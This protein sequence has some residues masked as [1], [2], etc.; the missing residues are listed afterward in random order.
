MK[1]IR[2][3]LTASIALL[4][5]APGL[6]ALADTLSVTGTVAQWNF[7]TLGAVA[8]GGSGT[9]NDNVFYPNNPPFTT[10]GTQ[11]NNNYGEPFATSLGM[12]NSFAY[13]SSGSTIAVGSVPACDI[14]STGGLAASGSYTANA[15]RIRGPASN[16]YDVTSGTPT[17]TGNGW[18]LLAPE[19]SQGAEFLA[20]TTGFNNIG[21]EFNYY[22]TNQGIRDMAVQYTTD[23]STWTTAQSLIS[24]PNDWY[25]SG[26]NAILIPFPASCDDDLNFGVRMVSAYDST[27]NIGD[28]Y[29]SATLKGSGKT[30]V[31]NDNSGNW[32]FGTVTIVTVA[33]VPE[34]ST[35]ALLA[36][37]GATA[38]IGSFRRKRRPVLRN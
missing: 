31:Y 33:S 3:C 26:Q 25:G 38:A 7:D 8:V 29:A 4:F 10:D 12:S 32:R 34:P 20:D 37:A 1:N 18:N 27:G 21:V 13:I 14:T 36:V 35:L 9:Y 19:Y 23:G 11:D 17:G 16:G 22:C 24:V 5:G 15:W 30:Q 2:F 28:Q 6:T